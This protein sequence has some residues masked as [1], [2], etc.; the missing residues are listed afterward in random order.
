MV[1]KGTLYFTSSSKSSDEENS[2][3]PNER[4]NETR[5]ARSVEFFSRLKYIRWVRR[6]KITI[7]QLMC[8]RQQIQRKR[9]KRVNQI[10]RSS[11]LLVADSELCNQCVCGSFYIYI[12]FFSS[13]GYGLPEKDIRNSKRNHPP[14]KKY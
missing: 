12:I 8:V 5:Q 14:Q 9:K 6:E 1:A 3:E 2:V 7:N 11:P 13:C 4:N 10:K